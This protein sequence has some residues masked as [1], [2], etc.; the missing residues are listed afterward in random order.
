MVGIKHPSRPPSCLHTTDAN[1]LRGLYWKVWSCWG[2]CKGFTF[3]GGLRL[4]STQTMIEFIRLIFQFY[5]SGIYSSDNLI[6]PEIQI[7]HQK[8]TGLYKFCLLSISHQYILRSLGT[9]IKLKST[10]R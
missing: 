7:V 6:L 4:A 2:L 3:T 5:S 8:V 10:W 1:H 9:W